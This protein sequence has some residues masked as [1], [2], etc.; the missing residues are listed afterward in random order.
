MTCLDGLT[1]NRA[2]I[3]PDSPDPAL[4]SPLIARPVPEAVTSTAAIIARL[5]R[6]TVASSDPSGGT[7]HATRRTRVWRFVDDVHLKFEPTPTG[8][9]LLTG[10]SQSRLGKG[11]L[12]Q[13]ARNL[14][15]LTRALEA[16]GR[17]PAAPAGPE[18]GGRTA[19]SPV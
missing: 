8:E 12:G 6:W 7:L 10:V 9:T 19:R 4:R 13:N 15:E 18:R 11:D 16:A 2:E 5:R 14:R 1:R 17:N 3:R